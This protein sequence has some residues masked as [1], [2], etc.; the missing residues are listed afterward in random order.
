MYQCVC[1]YSYLTGC[2]DLSL[3]I[4]AFR[5]TDRRIPYVIRR[6]KLK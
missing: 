2:V 5:K 3:L 4:D 6:I 1:V